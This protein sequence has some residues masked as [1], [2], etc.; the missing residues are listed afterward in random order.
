MN[1]SPWDADAVRRRLLSA[2]LQ[3]L[4]PESWVVEEV[5]FPKHGSY[6]AGVDRQFVR[7]LGKV[8][9]CQLGIALTFTTARWAV[10]VNWRLIMPDS[11]GRDWERR[12][13]ARVP[14]DELP[15]PYWQ[16]QIE[17]LDHMALEWGLPMAPLV[18]DTTSRGGGEA[19]LAALDLR[20]Q[21]YLVQAGPKLEVC[22][23]QASAAR[24]SSAPPGGGTAPW[25]GTV[26][27]LAMKAGNLPRETV[28]W[29]AR[30]DITVRR[31]QFVA[32]PVTGGTKPTP[33]ARTPGAP[34]TL[35]AEWPLGRS[36]PKNFWITNMTEQTIPR[37]VE[38]AKLR[39]LVGP[40]LEDFAERF[41]LRDYEGRTFTGWH[42]HVTLASAAHTYAVLEELRSADGT[43]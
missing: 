19:L 32:L 41:G 1:Q 28:E 29:C 21:P 10:P 25:H 36:R 14:D 38:L 31:S 5:H 12:S 23:D 33:G 24:G 37:L 39:E 27:D 35:L 4:S 8:R 16:Y 30:G 6:S 26:A 22:Y 7:S 9:N 11:W 17:A 2:L 18:V 43:G 15:R 13:R 34:R 40:R 20:H 42:H 3:E